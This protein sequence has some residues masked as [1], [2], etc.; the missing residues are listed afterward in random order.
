MLPTRLTVKTAQEYAQA[1][2]PHLEHDVY[3]CD[4]PHGEIMG[5]GCRTCA[6]EA[7]ISIADFRASGDLETFEKEMKPYVKKGKK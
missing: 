6:V 3:R 4:R 1:L 7:F 2:I 5:K